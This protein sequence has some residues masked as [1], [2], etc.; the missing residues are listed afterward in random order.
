[1]KIKKGNLGKMLALMLMALMVSSVPAFAVMA[2][3]GAQMAPAKSMSDFQQMY[4]W[5]KPGIA[6]Q[7]FH[8]YK[9]LQGEP[10]PTLGAERIRTAP[11]IL[12]EHFGTKPSASQMR[13]H[14]GVFTE[15][16]WYYE[17]SSQTKPWLRFERR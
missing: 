1:M 14:E 12:G 8:H 13:K 11:F 7:K 15:G 16:V 5:T 3:G 10:Q 4:S 6:H 2:A 9:R 17:S